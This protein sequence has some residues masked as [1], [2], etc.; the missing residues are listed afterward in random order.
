KSYIEQVRDR[1]PRYICPT[2]SSLYKAI[3]ENLENLCAL[4][5][6][7]S[8]ESLIKDEVKALRESIYAVNKNIKFPGWYRYFEIKKS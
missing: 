8:R 5:P 4:I 2:D 3:M 7:C 1:L 6:A